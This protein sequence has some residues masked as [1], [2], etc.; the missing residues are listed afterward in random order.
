MT[1]TSYLV[2]YPL[3]VLVGRNGHS[4]G[5]Q[6]AVATAGYHG[7]SAHY[8]RITTQLLCTGFCGLSMIIIFHVCQLGVRAHL[9]VVTYL[10]TW[11]DWTAIAVL[12]Y[13]LLPNLKW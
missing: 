13:L 12:L 10:L 1:D 6:A 3:R 4:G 5:W 7:H 2:G 8:S 9:T 11:L